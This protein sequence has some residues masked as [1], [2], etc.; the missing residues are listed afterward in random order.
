MPNPHIF[1]WIA[2]SVAAAA[3]VNPNVFNMLLARALSTFLHE[4]EP[5]FSNGPRG[6]LRYPPDCAILCNW[7]FGNLMLVVELFAKALWRFET[8]V[9]LIIIY[10]EN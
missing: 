5:V 8:C 4:G 7:V 6:L 3:A 10:V 2:A 9:Q 1:S